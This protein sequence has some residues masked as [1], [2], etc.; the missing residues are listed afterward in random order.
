MATER[1][2]IF[3]KML[4]AYQPIQTHLTETQV[5]IK[6]LGDAAQ[7]LDDEIKSCK[8][9]PLRRMEHTILYYDTML[10][11]LQTVMSIQKSIADVEFLTD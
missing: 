8:I 4:Y 6:E 10:Q 5:N 3:N 9:E 2:G 11:G 1:S 7:T